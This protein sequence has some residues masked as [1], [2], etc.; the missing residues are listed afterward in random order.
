MTPTHAIGSERALSWYIRTGAVA[1]LSFAWV[2]A[3]LFARDQLFPSSRYVIS[4]S[5][6]HIVLNCLY[7]TGSI[8]IVSAIA[9]TIVWAYLK[10]AHAE[11]SRSVEVLWS[12]SEF[13]K[14]ALI[15]LPITFTAV[16]A[17]EFWNW[18]SH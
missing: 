9:A 11:D 12:R 14:Y 6:R 13:R 10:R 3:Y 5:L 8:W 17:I 15:A 18:I 7:W 2:C 1:L 16:A 4:A